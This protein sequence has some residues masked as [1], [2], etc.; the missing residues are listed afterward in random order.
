MKRGLPSVRV[1]VAIAALAIATSFFIAYRSI[2]QNQVSIAAVE[3]TQQTLS[4]LSALQGAISDVIFATGDEAVT[5]AK[6]AARQRVDDLAMLTVDN[7]RQQERLDRLRGEINAL[8]A[9]PRV[10]TTPG[11]DAR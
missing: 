5:R 11:F 6:A 9:D 3:H 8:T 2:L 7:P 1:W 10:G 4:S